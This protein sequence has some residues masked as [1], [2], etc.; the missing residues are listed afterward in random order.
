MIVT[1]MIVTLIVVTAMLVTAL[2]FEFLREVLHESFVCT[3][4]ADSFLRMSRTKAS[5]SHAQLSV[6]EGCLAQKLPF[7]KLNFK[8]LKEVSHE[9]RACC[10]IFFGGFFRFWRV[11][12]SFTIPFKKASTSYF[13]SALVPRSGFGAGFGQDANCIG[14]AAASRLL[15][16][17]RA[18]VVPWSFAAQCLQITL[19]WLRHCRSMSL[20]RT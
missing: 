8:V 7:H 19:E 15:C 12:F 11:S 6:F 18:H 16:V 20:L 4:S 14:V 2:T 3:C 1:A 5:F 9:M 13:F 10:D 17:A